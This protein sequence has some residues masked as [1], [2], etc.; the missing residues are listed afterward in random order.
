M[1]LIYSLPIGL[2]LSCYRT[3]YLQR[4]KC[5]FF[6]SFRPNIFLL[7]NSA[8]VL[9]TTLNFLISL[10]IVSNCPLKTNPKVQPR[11]NRYRQTKP[12]L[13]TYSVDMKAS[14]S[15]CL[16]CSSEDHRAKQCS[17]HSDASSRRDRLTEIGRCSRCLRT[18]H[19]G[20]C[21]QS[22]KCNTCHKGNHND[23]FC[24]NNFRTKSQKVTKSDNAE[25]CTN[26]EV[27]TVV[28]SNQCT[29]YKYS[30]ALATAK[31]KVSNVNNSKTASV[32]CFFDPGS[33]I[34]CITSKL[35]KILQLESVE[36]R[37]LVLQGFHS[38]TTEGRF[39]HCCASSFLREKG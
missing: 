39:F 33:Q 5:L 2:F 32:R 31:V 26:T 1:C 27:N 29:S 14:K 12:K 35:V 18:Q 38:R 24:Y 28:L 6:R 17:Q 20:K 19:N 21:P 22:V 36:N 15:Q 8:Q 25:N 9:P 23:I 13:G 37:E 7:I 3:S 16:L 34:S 10:Q 11:C 4:K 30:S